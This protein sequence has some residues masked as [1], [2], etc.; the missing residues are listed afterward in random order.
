M[1]TLFL[2]FI[3]LFGTVQPQD[4]LYKTWALI[5]DGKVEEAKA[6]CEEVLRQ[7]PYVRGGQELLA[8]INLWLAARKGGTAKDIQGYL[9]ESR[10]L[11]FEKEATALLPELQARDA[12]EAAVKI[13]K[14]RQYEKFL[15]DFPG[16][17]Y[18]TQA[19]NRLAMAM[20]DEFNKRSTTVDKDKAMFYAIDEAAREYVNY[21]F[22][23][24]TGSLDPSVTYRTNPAESYALNKERKKVKLAVGITAN[25]AVGSHGGKSF[26]VGKN[27]DYLAGGGVSLRINDI[28]QPLNYVFSAQALWHYSK[29]TLWPYKTEGLAGVLYFDLNWNFFRRDHYAFF[30]SAGLMDEVL[31][32]WVQEFRGGVGIGWKHGEWRT[33]VLFLQQSSNHSNYWFSPALGTSFTYYF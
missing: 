13:D 3:L 28:A 4:G 23:A 20:A 18:E 32:S 26:F 21:A 10:E 6:A 27:P 33:G 8:D 17:S 31:P 19:K 16:C 22:S 9:L 24:A 1:K 5:R 12:F 7:D 2:F 25:G 29:Y 15:A 30:L 11:V 14:V